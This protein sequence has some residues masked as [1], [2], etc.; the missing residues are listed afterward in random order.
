MFVKRSRVEAS[1]S[2]RPHRYE[3][4]PALACC[5]SRKYFRC[6]S[7]PSSFDQWQPYP[8]LEAWALLIP[9]AWPWEGI[10]SQGFCGG[11]LPSRMRSSDDEPTSP[12]SRKT[13]TPL[14]VSH[15][16][17]PRWGFSKFF[18]S[19]RR[20]LQPQLEARVRCSLDR[21]CSYRPPGPKL[22]LRGLLILFH[23]CLIG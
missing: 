21:L 4:G 22:V 23:G 15:S 8:R 20:S 3:A 12:C 14:S 10:G 2:S 17:D 11:L 7:S 6:R 16:S 5:M 19:P 18:P 1:F 13:Y 9:R